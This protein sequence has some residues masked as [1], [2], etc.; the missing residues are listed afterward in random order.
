MLNASDKFERF[1]KALHL[2]TPLFYSDIYSTNIT[3]VENDMIIIE[4]MRTD[5]IVYFNT[6]SIFKE[7]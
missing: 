3:V 1:K 5:S 4:K 2:H 6:K 7:Y